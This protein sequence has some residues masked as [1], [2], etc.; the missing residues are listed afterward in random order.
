MDRSD[1]VQTVSAEPV[2]YYLF[3]ARM[4]LHPRHNAQQAASHIVHPPRVATGE[5]ILRAQRLVV[6]AEEVELALVQHQDLTYLEPNVSYCIL[7]TLVDSLT[8]QRIKRWLYLPTASHQDCFDNGCIYAR[9]CFFQ[10]IFC[11]LLRAQRTRWLRRG[12]VLYGCRLGDHWGRARNC[13]GWRIAR[14][15]SVVVIHVKSWYSCR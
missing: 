9:E 14:F 6:E 5:S 13:S 4:N 15:C 12:F 10:S 8:K 11:L 2:P 7:R 3:V 1:E